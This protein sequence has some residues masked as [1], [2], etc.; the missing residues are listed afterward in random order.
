ML[1]DAS[2]RE[3]TR[4]ALRAG[5]TPGAGGRLCAWCSHVIAVGTQRARSSGA[6]ARRRERLA[7]LLCAPLIRLT[8]PARELPSTRRSTRGDTISGI[9]EVIAFR[10][11]WGWARRVTT[12][13]RLDAR[14]AAALAVKSGA[15]Q[16]S[17]NR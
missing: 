4:V 16:G 2:A 5:G 12:R 11:L 1:E 3:T 7:R 8:T 17:R 6:D 9:V 15:V 13:E 14:T 10:C